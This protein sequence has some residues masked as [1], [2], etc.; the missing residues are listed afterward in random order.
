MSKY[1]IAS[2]YMICCYGAFK[3]YLTYKNYFLEQ[4]LTQSNKLLSIKN[5]MLTFCEKINNN[6]KEYNNTLLLNSNVFNENKSIEYQNSFKKNG[7]YHKKKDIAFSNTEMIPV[8]MGGNI[9]YTKKENLNNNLCD[10]NNNEI[11]CKNMEEKEINNELSQDIIN[12]IENILKKHKL[13]LFMK[14]TAL[15]PF[16]KYSKLAINILKL[17]KAKEIYTVNILNDDMLKQSLKIYSNWPTFPQLYINGKFVGGIDK[18]Q[19]LHDNKKL[20]EMLQTI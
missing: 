3:I 5:N 7:K 11:D 9:K 13:V 12:L 2:S 10:M 1:K 16:C 15:N 4:D 17:N 6:T 19:E 8:E 14:G 20:E 18:I